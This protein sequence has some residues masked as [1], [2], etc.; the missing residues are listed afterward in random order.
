MSVAPSFTASPRGT[1]TRMGGRSA[2]LLV[3][4]LVLFS[5]LPLSF[6]LLRL[7]QLAGLSDVMPPAVVTPLPLVI[8]I[9]G[10]L[11]YA[12]LGALQFSPAGRRRWPSW[13]RAAGRVSLVGASLVVVSAL[14]LTA[15]YA[16][17]TAGGLMLAGFRVA[18]AAGM[19]LSIGLG[20]A[21]VLRRD[22]ARHR[23]WMIRAYALGLGSATQMIVLMVAEIA[24]GGPPNDLNR[25]L[26]MGLA[27]S[28]NLAVAEWRIRTTRGAR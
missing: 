22:I 24:T 4:S 21:A 8:H 5:A 1:V 10:A 6:G 16:T 17:L 11:L 13:H 9:V 15:S 18:V 12:V 14:W 19:A 23:E 26:L 27:W 28:L 25:A 20:L 3:T 2:K 7:L